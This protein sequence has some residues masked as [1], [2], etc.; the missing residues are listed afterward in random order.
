MFVTE[1]QVM[2][3]AQD[4]QSDF[5]HGNLH[6]QS[7]IPSIAQRAREELA[8][9]NLPTRKSLCFVIAKQAQLMFHGNVLSVKRELK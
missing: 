5:L 1:D 3:I 6:S 7:S 2:E 9:R 4:L 8:D